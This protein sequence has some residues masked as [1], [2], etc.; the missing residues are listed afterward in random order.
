MICQAL[1]RIK[2]RGHDGV[3]HEIPPGEIFT[4]LYPEKIAPLV[5][6]GKVKIVSPSEERKR[7]LDAC[8]SATIVSIRDEIIRGGKWR[9]FP[10]THAVE[11]EIEKIQKDIFEV[12][13]KLIDFREAC[14]RWEKAGCK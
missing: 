10:E 7:N 14:E 4:P 5:E 9:P 11:R 6:S 8:M 13:G 3:V 2:I 1:S 12:K